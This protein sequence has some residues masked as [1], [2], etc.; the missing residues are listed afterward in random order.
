MTATFDSTY[1][2]RKQLLLCFFEPQTN[3]DFSVFFI[4]KFLDLLK[5]EALNSKFV[6]VIDVNR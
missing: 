5:R 1:N 3:L 4:N 2:V 6:M